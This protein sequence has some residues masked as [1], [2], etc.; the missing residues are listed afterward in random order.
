MFGCSHRFLKSI[1]SLD[2]H[3]GGLRRLER[4][5]QAQPD[6]NHSFNGLNFVDHNDQALL[7]LNLFSSRRLGSPRRLRRLRVLGL[8]KRAA[9]T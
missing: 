6:G 7:L 1:S 8:L 9:N 5:T 4:L 3:S 2:D